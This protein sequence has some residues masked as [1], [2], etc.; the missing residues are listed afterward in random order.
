MI[1][2]WSHVKFTWLPRFKEQVLNH[3]QGQIRFSLPK[4][5]G[6]VDHQAVKNVSSFKGLKNVP[7]NNS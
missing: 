5:H 7:T 6:R 1:I 4:A 2:T 3:A